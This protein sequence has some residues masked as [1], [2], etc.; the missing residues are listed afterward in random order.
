[1]LLTVTANFGR[2]FML[3]FHCGTFIVE[4]FFT[5]EV[6]KEWDFDTNSNV[7]YTFI[8]FKSKSED[9]LKSDDYCPMALL[10]KWNMTHISQFFFA[11]SI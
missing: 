2:S 7:T 8:Y 11:S 1:M 4:T 9:D 5:L 6:Q 10:W 3:N